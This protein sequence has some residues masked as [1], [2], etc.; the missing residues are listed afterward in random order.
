VASGRVADQ[1]AFETGPEERLRAYYERM[2]DP[3]PL[4]ARSKAEWL[5]RRPEIR[6]RTI[7]ALGLDPMPDRLPLELRC[8]GVLEREGYRVERIYW[9]TWPRV[10]A[11]GWLYRPTAV[12]GRLAA[13]LNPHGHWEN[14]AR[15]PTVQSRLIGLAKLGYVALAPDSVHVYD[16]PVGLTPLSVMTYNNLRALDLLLS[17]AEVDRERIGVTGASG[18]AQQ[19]MYLLAVDDRIRAGVLAV[20]VSYFKRILMPEGHHCPCN[21]VPGI[22]RFTDE[23]ELCAVASPKA[24]MFLTV[25]GDWTAPFPE[26][27]LGELRALYRMWGQ[28]DRLAHRQWE[29]PHDYHQEM[30]EAAYTWF[31][32]ELRGNAAAGNVFELPHEV[33]PLEVLNGLDAP[34][35]GDRGADGIR[36]WYRKR[37][38]AQ[39]PQ[40]EG[41]PARRSYQERVREELTELLG[42]RVEP[43]TRAAECNRMQRNPTLLSIRS[44][45]DVRVPAI[46]LPPEGETRGPVVIAAHPEGKEAAVR[47]PT[48]QGLRSA[49]YAVLA[50]DVRLKGEMARE[51]LHNSIIWGRPEAGMAVT[52]L[53]AWVDWLWEQEGVDPRSVVLLGEGELGVAALLAAGLDERITATVA[54]CMQTTYRDG[55]EGLPV[56]PNI[57]RVADVPQI[58]SLAAPRPLWL[59]RVPGERVGFSSRRYYDWTR[60]SHQSLGELE[61]LKMSTEGLPGAEEL[62]AWLEPRL[63]RARRGQ[64][65]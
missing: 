38:V 60:R 56:I 64:V 6:R 41:K 29:G 40:I 48:V 47:L 57:L 52:D 42:L 9:Q 33:E 46:W 11:S 13:V 61:A 2:V 10:W 27:E 45:L 51:W 34:P 30:R 43:V 44:E 53:R 17:L 39:P 50:P 37:V 55:G 26:E 21:H 25:T 4:R 19:A 8:G 54:D 5:Q 36:E 18:G 65:G 12:E 3:R 58:A 31:E 24:L 35:E 32:R 49:G 20:L 14:G 59:Y 28:E 15:H 23:L 62:A 63:R 7:A 16:Y 22:M 1:R